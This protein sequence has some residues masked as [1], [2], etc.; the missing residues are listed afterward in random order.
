LKSSK[1]LRTHSSTFSVT[2]PHCFPSQSQTETDSFVLQSSATL[3]TGRTS[4]A[5]E[6]AE[7]QEHQEVSNMILGRAGKRRRRGA[8]DSA[9]TGISGD[10]ESDVDN[11][12]NDVPDRIRSVRAPSSSGAGTKQD[13]VVV[14][15]Q[16]FAAPKPSP[17]AP[18]SVIVGSALKRNADGTVAQPRVI[19][20]KA[21]G[22]KVYTVT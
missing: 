10:E 6:R 20:R 19:Q 1:N 13:P 22:K 15:D 12:N 18:S 9:P 3:G 21:K 2:N 11:A 5:K 16:P 17:A 8:L 4:T 7:H 14:V